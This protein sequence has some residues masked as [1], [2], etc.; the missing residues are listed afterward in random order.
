MVYGSFRHFTFGKYQDLP[1][2][3]VYVAAPN[4]IEW[5]LENVEGFCISDLEEL[6]LNN[7]SGGPDA[8]FYPSSG[9]AWDF[10]DAVDEEA[11]FKLFRDPT[12]G[13][14]LSTDE[15]KVQFLARKGYDWY[16][17]TYKPILKQHYFFSQK[18]LDLNWDN[19]DKAG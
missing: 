11:F 19:L 5:C 14:D 2:W 10:K 6:I 12:S 8:T 1:V 7:K 13:W 15:N 16:V 3:A 17:S 18:H 4:Y 9:A